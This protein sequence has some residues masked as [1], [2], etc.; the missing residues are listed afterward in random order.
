MLSPLSARKAEKLGYKNVKVFHAGIP[1]WKK[2]GNIVV[3][4]SANIEH[5]NKTEA[6]YILLDLRSKGQIE[7]GHLPKAVA[8]ADAKVDALKA[9]F[10]SYKA[11][12]IIL[13]N[14]NGNVAKATEAYKTIAG[15]GYSQVSILQGGFEG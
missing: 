11:A 2:A 1:A 9:Q 5:L 10:P 8:A 3:S 4:N 14:Q 6:P 7:K 13:Y 12:P 15:W